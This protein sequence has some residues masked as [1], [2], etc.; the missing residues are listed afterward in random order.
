M[1]PTLR[2]WTWLCLLLL[3]TVAGAAAAQTDVIRGH[4]TT[5]D[6]LPLPGVRVTATSFPGNVTR[7]ARSDTRGAFQIAFPNGA[8]D[9][10]MGYSLIGY[11]F[12]Q[13]EVKRTADQEVLI[14]DARLS[15]V[16]LDTVSVSAPVQQKINRYSG[17]P[18]VGGTERQ[19]PT[20]GLPPD[21]QGDL[22]APMT[23]CGSA[24][25]RRSPAPG[26]PSCTI[27]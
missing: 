18:D 6:G 17:T 10:I 27:S 14:A 19:I 24:P 5:I 11:V 15:V 4:V 2:R 21:V 22:N 8:G 13:F 26:H 1:K 3:A 7:E 20:S 12:R 9:Y 23:T 16:Q 25:C